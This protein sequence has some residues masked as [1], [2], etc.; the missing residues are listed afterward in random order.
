MFNNQNTYDDA[1]TQIIYDQAIDL[2]NELDDILN[3]YKDW[4]IDNSKPILNVNPHTA[5][6]EL[7]CEPLPFLLFTSDMF[8]TTVNKIE[9]HRQY[10]I[11]YNLSINIVTMIYNAHNNVLYVCINDKYHVYLQNNQIYMNLI[12]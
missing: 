4:E 11:Y 5:I 3:N 12:H 8:V 6:S 10:N 1:T 2:S 7:Q 9:K